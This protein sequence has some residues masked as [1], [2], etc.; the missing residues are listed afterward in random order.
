[1]LEHVAFKC[2]NEDL[3]SLT[4][5]QKSTR[6]RGVFLLDRFEAIP[7]LPLV[8]ISVVEPLLK[9]RTRRRRLTQR[10]V[11]DVYRNTLDLNEKAMLIV[12]D[13]AFLLVSHMK[14]VSR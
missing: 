7:P 5:R 11:I 8:H 2:L 3:V 4:K 14:M 12:H 13:V 10:L 1:M 9:A 6:Q